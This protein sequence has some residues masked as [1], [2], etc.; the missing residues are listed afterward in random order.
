MRPI[1]R[2]G[3]AAVVALVAL[4]MALPMTAASVNTKRTRWVDDDGRAGPSNC[5]GRR[6]ATKSIQSAINR[7]DRNDVVIV[8]P[9]TY[10]GQV[11]IVGNSRRGMTL[12]AYRQGTATLRAPASHKEGP[13]LY[14]ERVSDVTVR[15]LNITFSSTGCQTREWDVQG[16]WVEDADGTGIVANTIKA[17]GSD[18]QGACGYDDGMRVLSSTRVRVIGNQFRDFKSDGI[19]FERRSRGLIADNAVKFYHGS[20]GSDD[21]GSQGIR[22][23]ED[24]RAEVTRNAVGS[25]SRNGTPK[26]EIGITTQTGSIAYI[27]RNDVWYAKTGIGII[28]GG[29]D[30]VSN[31]VRGAGLELGIHVAAGSGTEVRSNRV[32]GHDTGIYVEVS[33]TELRNNDARGNEVHGCYDS[34]SG[35]GTAGTANLWSSS[36]QGSPESSPAGIC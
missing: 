24:S 15:G 32:R 3:L 11:G 29:S 6:P 1:S 8:C 28:A 27:H 4:S 9:G 10:S 16:I 14:V 19:S 18:T 30:V 17:T 21:D 34:T 36:N 12:R 26:I 23:E 35:S 2:A 20:S 25:L 31:D 33:G 5:G 22:L 13:L 7:S